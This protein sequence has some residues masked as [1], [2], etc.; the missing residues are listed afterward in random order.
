[1]GVCGLLGVMEGCVLGVERDRRNA[2]REYL[3]NANPSFQ[4]CLQNTRQKMLLHFYANRWGLKQLFN[5]ASM[6]FI[7]PLS[8]L[9][10]R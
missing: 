7:K 2:G 5:A 9:L 3:L 6:Y 4:I 10:Q 1:M 8:L